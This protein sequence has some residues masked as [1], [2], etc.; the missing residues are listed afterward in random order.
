[1]VKNL[2]EVT[3]PRITEKGLMTIDIFAENMEAE[4]I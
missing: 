3:D 4:K 1:M 2:N